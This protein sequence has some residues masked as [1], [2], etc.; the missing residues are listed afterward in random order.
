MTDANDPA[1]LRA[2]PDDAAAILYAEAL[3]AHPPEGWAAEASAAASRDA[4]AV[5]GENTSPKTL[6]LTRAKLIIA[7]MS[8]HSPQ[9]RV[10]RFPQLGLIFQAAAA[11]LIGLG[12]FTGAVSEQLT[13]SGASLNLLSPPFLAVILWNIA[14]ALWAVFC[15]LKLLPKLGVPQGLPLRLAHW[16][17]SLSGLS[18][19]SPVRSPADRQF[20]REALPL[21]LPQTAWRLR[22]ALHWAALAFAAGAAASLCVRGIGTAYW[23]YWESTWFADRPDIIAQIL[24]VLYGWL[25]QWLPGIT[26]LPDAAGLEALRTAGAAAAAPPSEAAL[27]A[28]APW[29]ARLIWTLVLAVMLPRALLAWISERAAAR[30]A[31]ELIFSIPPER[32]QR[33]QRE[34]A[35]L[36]ARVW[37]ICA[38]GKPAPAASPNEILVAADPWSAPD[39]PSLAQADICAGDLASLMLDPAATPEDEVHGTLID[40]LLARKAVLEVEL[41][42]ALL[43]ERFSDAP[44]R[45]QSRRALW[46]HFC[47]E[48]GV[49]AKI[50]GLGG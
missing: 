10:P 27:A 39:F 21:L 8:E 32:W 43:A 47:A 4:R 37:R 50:T 46:E 15:L 33:I 44:E 3:E 48:R 19:L 30:S 40:A 16:M 13:S 49:R 1:R 26:P 2:Q 41:D 9:I 18:R 7:R 17:S 34:A 20:Y 38:T 36:P 31:R 5:A 29:L 25:P 28:G 22:A 23:A 24:S 42:F 6:L 14:A 12:F 45:I 11:L 35:A